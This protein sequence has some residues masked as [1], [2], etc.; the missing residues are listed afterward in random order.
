MAPLRPFF[1]LALVAW[2]SLADQ[3]VGGDWWVPR[4]VQ[5]GQVP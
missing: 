4:E 1:I 5:V 3:G 2:V